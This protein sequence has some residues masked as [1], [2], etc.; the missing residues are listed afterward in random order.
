MRTFKMQD[1]KYSRKVGQTLRHARRQKLIVS[2]GTI[3]SRCRN[4]YSANDQREVGGWAKRTVRSPLWFC[5][6]T[7]CAAKTYHQRGQIEVNKWS[8]SSYLP[9]S[10]RMRVYMVHYL[11]LL[12]ILAAVI[13][14]QPF[15]V[16][17]MTASCSWLK[18]LACWKGGKNDNVHLDYTRSLPSW[19]PSPGLP[20]CCEGCGGCY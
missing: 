3:A 9:H 19:Q 13:R 4:H 5:R 8:F 6:F 12:S 11:V 2:L 14:R 16:A 17:A 18:Y 10:D 7:M 20:R 1:E 15:V